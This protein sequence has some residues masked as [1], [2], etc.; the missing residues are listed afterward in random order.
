M[1]ELHEEREDI[2]PS[3]IAQW[4]EDRKKLDAVGGVGGISEYAGMPRLQLDSHLRLLQEKATLRKTIIAL[5][6]A[7]GRC[8]EPGNESTEVIS[9]ATD[10]L[11]KITKES[12][13]R[14]SLETAGSIIEGIGIQEF[15]QPSRLHANVVPL[16]EAWRQMRNLVPFFKPGQLIVLA[17]FTSHGKSA[18]ALHIAL[19]LAQRHYPVAMF[20]MEMDKL[21]ITQR[22]TS[23]MASVDSYVHQNGQM[24]SEERIRYQSSA[25]YLSTLPLS[26]DDTSGSTVPAIAAAISKANPRP[27]FV[28]VDYL[29]IMEAVGRIDTRAAAVSEVSRGLKRIA[30]QFKIPVLALSQFNRDASKQG[31]KPELHDLRESGSIEQDANIAILLSAKKG[32]EHQAAMEVDVD[33]AKNRSGRRGQLRM[34]FMK[35]FSQFEEIS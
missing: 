31:R 10:L 12:M 25:S 6:N 13:S 33:I 24:T 17:A 27:K 32:Q 29:Q 3:R 18:M 28:I 1:L 21:E 23:H 4:L 8:M 20:S 16:P 22:A 26:I 7:I 11:E 35:P 14:T 34:M 30:M 19:S 2:G 9:Y 5:H 15:C